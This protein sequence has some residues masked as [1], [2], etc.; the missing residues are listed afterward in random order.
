MNFEDLRRFGRFSFKG[1][2]K[3]VEEM[4][5]AEERGEGSG[6]EEE[7]EE[8]VSVSAKEMAERYSTLTDSSHILGKRRRGEVQ[9]TKARKR[10]APDS[11]G[12][13]KPV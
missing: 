8:G 10:S 4:A 9:P 11:L 7:E 12:F 5:K 3:E 13:L 1:F 6:E 2:N